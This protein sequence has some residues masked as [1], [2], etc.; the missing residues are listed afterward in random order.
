MP[1]AGVTDLKVMIG[2]IEERLKVLERMNYG[3]AGAVGLFIIGAILRTV[4]SSV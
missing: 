1:D 4:V 3:V 2:R